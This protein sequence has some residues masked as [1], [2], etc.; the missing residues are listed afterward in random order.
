MPNINEYIPNIATIKKIKQ[1]TPD[2][3]T[4]LL[5]LKGAPFSKKFE[6]LPGQFLELSLV[7]YGEAPFT[8]ASSPNGGTFEVSVKKVG[9]V[10]GALHTLKRGAAVGIRG[11]Y[12]NTFPLDKLRRKDILFVAGGIGMA[13][14]RS[15]LQYLFEHRRQ[16]G[17]VEIVYGARTPR[18]L[19][20]K[21]E[22][23]K[24]A[25]RYGADVYLTVDL[26]DTGWGGACGVVCALFPKVKMNPA[27]SVAVVC[28]PPPMIGPAVTDLTG[29][30]FRDADIYCSLER[31]MKCGIGKCGHCYCKSKYVC[32]D[33][34][35]FSLAQMKEF[36][37]I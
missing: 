10:S 35:N 24:W 31:Y 23:K 21:D 36:G 37:L 8:F 16:F 13:P 27:K 14:L 30:G 15:L 11:P 19:V 33:G 4:F 32:L 25:D 34:P 12:G 7:G 5:E 29:L 9:A 22:T 6:F 1:E 18:D 26:P 3:K 2:V 28:G 20:Y 17:K